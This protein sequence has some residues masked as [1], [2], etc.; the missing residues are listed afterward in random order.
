MAQLARRDPSALE[1]P[2]WFGRRLDPWLDEWWPERLTRLVGVEP[3]RLEEVRDGDHLVVRAELPG[4]D[5]D[6][7]VQITITDGVLTIAG[8]RSEHTEDKE[9]DSYRSEFR[10]G[11]FRRSIQ[12]PAGATEQDVTATYR[13]GVLE[14]RVPVPTSEPT[15]ASTTVPV[16]RA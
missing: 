2:R 7:D 14:V 4:I 3:V 10:Y 8:E 16:T 12:L 1:L 6:K 11:S 5:P 9:K 15:P 13:D